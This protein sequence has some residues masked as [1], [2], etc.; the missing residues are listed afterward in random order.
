MVHIRKKKKKKTILRK[1]QGCG[2][3]NGGRDHEPNEARNVSQ[4]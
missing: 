2:F 4:L 3:E 1:M